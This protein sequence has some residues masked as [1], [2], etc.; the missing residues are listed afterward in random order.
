MK[1]TLTIPE[2]LNV[3]FQNRKDTYTGKLAYV[4]YTDKTG[5]LRKEASWTSWCDKKIEKLELKNEPTSG[6]VLNRDVGGARDSY[7]SWNIRIEKVRVY[8]PRGFEFEIDIPNLLFVLQECSAIKG[9]G[10]EGEFVYSWNGTQLIL[11]PVTSQEYTNSVS[12]GK[13][14]EEK[15]SQ[16]EMVVGC[17]Y[18]TKKKENVIYMG[19]HPW[20]GIPSTYGCS[21]AGAAKHVFAR[22]E[23]IKSR[24]SDSVSKLNYAD[25]NAYIL[26]TGF[27]KLAK[28]T[29]TSP[30]PQYIKIHDILMKSCLLSKPKE[31]ILTPS[32]ARSTGN[33]YYAQAVMQV[34]DKILQ[35]Q[36]HSSRRGFGFRSDP[37]INEFQG[38]H[39]ISLKN[40]RIIQTPY[41]RQI[42][43]AN[44][45]EIREKCKSLSVVCENEAKVTIISCEF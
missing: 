41:P 10:L 32:T 36:L 29:S 11:L 28:R 35:G 27:T 19:K 4:V 2:T 25:P 21:K 8:D 38:H 13:L 31:L 3:G 24:W 33:Y 5:K 9:K 45:T 34:D 30:V 17:A 39:I 40:G 37:E 7:S 22:M 43:M 26:D 18:L 16:E 6:F 1:D 44:P 12:Y 15:V 14:Q 20:W 23:S 42:H